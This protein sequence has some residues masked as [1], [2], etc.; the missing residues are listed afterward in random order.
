MEVSKARNKAVETDFIQI[1][2]IIV[3]GLVCGSCISLASCICIAMY[4]KRKWDKSATNLCKRL[5][6]GESKN[7]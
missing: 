3:G 1:S 4:S 7:L 6:R 2:C 5:S